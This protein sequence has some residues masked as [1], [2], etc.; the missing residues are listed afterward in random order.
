M[1][2]A[3]FNFIMCSIIALS[4]I[5][6]DWRTWLWYALG[7]FVFGNAYN[8]ALYALALLYDQTSRPKLIL[9]TC[10]WLCFF[11]TLGGFYFLFLL[12]ISE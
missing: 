1:S 10:F 12:A 3:L 6:Y 2:M 9:R 7:F 4:G 11:P 8:G 5:L